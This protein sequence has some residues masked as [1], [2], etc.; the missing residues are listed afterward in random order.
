M[1]VLGWKIKAILDYVAMGLVAIAGVVAADSYEL[2][3]M[4][5]AAGGLVKAIAEYL[6][7]KGIIVGVQ[8]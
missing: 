2:S 8:K 7:Q 5:V 4:L 6:Y 3:V 1:I